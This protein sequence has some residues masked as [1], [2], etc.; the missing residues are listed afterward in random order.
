MRMPAGLV[1]KIIEGLNVTLSLRISSLFQ[2]V[3]L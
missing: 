2:L 1:K 3:E